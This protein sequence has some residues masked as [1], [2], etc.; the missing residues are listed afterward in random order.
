M[1][2]AHAVRPFESISVIRIDEEIE[3][4]ATVAEVVEE[5]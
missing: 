4:S 2:G 3:T 1:L 5:S